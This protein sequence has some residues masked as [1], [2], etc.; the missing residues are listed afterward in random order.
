M[1]EAEGTLVGSLLYNADLFDCKTIERMVETFQ[2]LAQSIVT[3][4]SRYIVDLPILPEAE[5]E[6]L[7]IEWNDTQTDYAAEKCAHHLFEA[8]AERTPNAVAAVFGDQQLTYAE[9]NGRANQLAHYLSRSGIVAEALVGLCMQPSLEMVVGLLGILKAGGAYV[10]LNPFDSIDRLS[11]ILSDAQISI[12]LTQQNLQGRLTGY[13]GR[14]IC[15][16]SEWENIARE[17]EQNPDSDVG[18]LNVA[19]AIYTSGSMGRPKGVLIPHQA[20]VNHNVAIAERYGLRPEDRVLQFYTISFD[21]AAEE[22]FPTWLAGAA[23]VLRPDGVADTIADFISF[24]EKERLTVINIPTAYWQEWVAAITRTDH[25]WPSAMW[26]SALR[27]LIV[28]SEK[29]LSDRLATWRKVAD[30]RIRWINAYGPTEATI[31]ATIYEPDSDDLDY[32]TA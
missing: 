27:L 7:L 22:L 24:L 28:G 21:A 16:D 19:Y 31:T 3:D 30:D 25:A 14:A 26:P 12:L 29:A 8:Q 1:V 20:L 23:V 4:P 13:N 15:L 10:P 6:R 2:V 5:R 9:L 11:L 18:P 32:K 17:S